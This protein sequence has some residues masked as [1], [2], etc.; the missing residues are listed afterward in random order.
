MSFPHENIEI[1]AKTGLLA[2]SLPEEYGG[3]GATLLDLALVLEQLAMACPSTALIV[4]AQSGFGAKAIALHGSD[5]M[6]SALL[7]HFCSG[8]KLLS[9]GMSE[10]GAGSDIGNMR[11]NAVSDGTDF[12]VSGEKTWIS[13]ATVA[14]VFLIVTRFNGEPGLKGLGAVVMPRD[15][16]GL[17][18]GPKIET[19]GIRG[20]GMASVHLDNCRVPAANVLLGPGRYR[21]LLHIMNGER[22]AGNPPISLGI[23]GAALAAAQAY[24][25]TREVSGRKLQD[26][27]GLRW[28]FADMV[29]ALEAAR[30]LVYRAAA[31]AGSDLASNVH[32]SVAKIAANEAAIGIAD[33]A[34]QMHGAAGYTTDFD[35]E[36][37]FR[38]ARGLSIGDGTVEVQRNV[39]AGEMLGRVAR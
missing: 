15:T 36:R 24:L 11:T 28:K 31:E 18:V 27:Q 12:L 26:F 20:T 35:V 7:P 2:I 16:P 17:E 1:L 37:M 39:I 10:P 13:L 32:A 19:L 4:G 38:D 21:D 5:D 3:G 34:L 30:M 33:A 6:K 22:A 25:A 9:W 23:A 14:D 8:E 29:V